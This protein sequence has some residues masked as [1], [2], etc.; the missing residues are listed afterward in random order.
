MPIS[1]RS[2]GMLNDAR[3][4]GSPARV[5]FSRIAVPTL[6]VSIEDDRFGTAATAR[7]IAAAVPDARL[8]IYPSGGHIWLGHDE[9]VSEEIVRFVSHLEGGRSADR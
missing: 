2:R 9:D 5:D 1:L 4:A 7:D 8:V 3:L 6:V